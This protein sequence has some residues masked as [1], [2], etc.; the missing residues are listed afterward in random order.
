VELPG[1]V[2]IEVLAAGAV[3]IG[4][5]ALFRGIARSAA[6]HAGEIMT[7]ARDAATAV[8]AA[9]GLAVLLLTA[10]TV[11]RQEGRHCEPPAPQPAQYPRPP[12]QAHRPG[13]VVHTY[14]LYPPAAEPAPVMESL[15]DEALAETWRQ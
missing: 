10:R 1:R 15:D 12:R 3:A 8:I 9:A 13:E 11:A 2:Q 5:L 4:G 7:V 6:A 14:T